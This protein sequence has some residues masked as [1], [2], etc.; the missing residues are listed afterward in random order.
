MQFYNN[1]LFKIKF[2]KAQPDGTAQF[3]PSQGYMFHGNLIFHFITTVCYNGVATN[4][5]W[6]RKF[7]FVYL[8]ALT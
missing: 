6:L 8:C 1:F 4:L 5:V 3:G 2:D 7:D